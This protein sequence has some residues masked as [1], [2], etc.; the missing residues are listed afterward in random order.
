MLKESLC[1]SDN[2]VSISSQWLGKLSLY[3]SV[4]KTKRAQICISLL[5]KVFKPQTVRSRNY[6]H[7]EIF[8]VPAFLI[9]FVSDIS[10]ISAWSKAESAA[11]GFVQIFIYFLLQSV[12]PCVKL[13]KPADEVFAISVTDERAVIASQSLSCV[14]DELNTGDRIC[15]HT[16]RNDTIIAWKK[17][18]DLLLKMS[19]SRNKKWLCSG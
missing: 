16:C 8:K 11:H 12:F 19:F 1:V 5:P 15:I 7:L 18:K 4:A 17:V 14:N 10:F 3:E 9:S 13:A 2:K 6:K